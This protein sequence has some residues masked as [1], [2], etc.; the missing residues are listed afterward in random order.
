VRFRFDRDTIVLWGTV[1]TE[2]DRAMVQMTVFTIM[3]V[4]SLEDHIQVT[5]GLSSR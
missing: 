3:H 4:Y 5:G 2:S 1:P